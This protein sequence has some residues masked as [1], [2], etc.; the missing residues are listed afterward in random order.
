M[1]SKKGYCFNFHFSGSHSSSG[2]MMCEKC[3]QKV[4]P[5]AQDWVSYTLPIKDDWKYATQHRD[6]TDDQTGWVKIEQDQLKFDNDVKKAIE[7]INAFKNNDGE[8][9][10]AFLV[11]LDKLGLVE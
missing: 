9:T 7:V 3:N 11:A 1:I 10:D 2:N 5:M 6:C 8:Y 4:T